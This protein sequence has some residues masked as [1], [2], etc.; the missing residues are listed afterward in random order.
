MMR[1]LIY[2]FLIFSSSYIVAQVT[3]DMRLEVASQKEKTVCYNIDVRQFGGN[4]AVMLAGQNYRFFYSSESLDFDESSW[5]LKLKD[6][7][8][9]FKLVQHQNK[10]DATG[11]G[12][13]AF[14]N[15]LGF[16]NASIILNGTNSHGSF[17]KKNAWITLA[18]MCFDKVGIQ[19]DQ[20]VVIARSNLTSAYG[21][22]YV[23]LSYVD[24]DGLIQSL[25]IRSTQ[26]I[27]L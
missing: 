19:A 14:E 9:T 26:D 4:D 24:A 8:Y 21:R 12:T 20:Q 13:L 25:P 15:D 11:V 5:D 23:E 18:K 3:T 17:L 16:I 6:T 27:G 22:A 2:A 10:V 7:E 1:L